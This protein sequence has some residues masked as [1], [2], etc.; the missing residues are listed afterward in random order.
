MAI[1][2]DTSLSMHGLW[3]NWASLLC[4]KVIE[5]A[6]DFRLHVGYLEFNEKVSVFRREAQAFFSRD[7]E[8]LLER[9]RWAA[10]GGCTN[11]E[12]PLNV[13]LREFQKKGSRQMGRA[14]HG[15][16]HILFLTD[17]HPNQGDCTVS[18]QIECARELGILVHTIF[19]GDQSCPPVLDDMSLCTSGTR[20]MAV[21]DHRCTIQVEE[22]PP[23]RA[24]AAEWPSRSRDW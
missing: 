4:A 18:Q 22:R 17:G 7:Y 19:V 8:P 1:I 16:Q 24:A 11:Y 9:V 15:N 12:M 10:C 13:A 20:H 14:Q 2:R 21:M 3:D 6:R 23:G 5:L